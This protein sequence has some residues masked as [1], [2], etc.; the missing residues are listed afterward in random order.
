M[1]DEAKPVFGD[2]DGDGDLDLLVGRLAGDFSYFANTGDA[3]NPQFAAAL[4][5]P[6]G[7]GNV[8]T[9]SFAPA[10]G[11]I[12]ADGDLDVFVGQS[13]GVFS[14]FEN[15]GGA[16]SPAF[17]LRIDGLNPLA[18]RD[19][20]SSSTP[21]LADFD[22]DGDLDL[23]AG[24]S[25]GSFNYFK[26]HGSAT[27]PALAPLTGAANPLSGED[28]GDDSAPVAGALNGDGFPDLATG[29]QAGTF[30]VHYFP[31]PARGLLL[32]AGIALLRWL[33]RRRR[34]R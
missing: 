9:N 25:D 2:V 12:D 11:D 29:S 20:G 22:R 10:F 14:Y 6:F 27:G 5:N 23:V 7:L 1:G 18:G 16:T 28:V 8:G 13:T 31:E 4:A 32:G 33:D 3:I 21:T 17:L 34:G 26:N 30:A 24:E 19:V 15:T